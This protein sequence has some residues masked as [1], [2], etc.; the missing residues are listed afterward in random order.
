[1]WD[2]S[3]LKELQVLEKLLW[4]LQT[5]DRG[6]GCFDRIKWCINSARTLTKIDLSKGRISFLRFIESECN[7]DE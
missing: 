3:R 2:N 5:I 1:M 6:S 4:E 7:K